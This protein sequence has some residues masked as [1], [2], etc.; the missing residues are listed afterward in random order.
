LAVTGAILA[1]LICLVFRAYITLKDP[2]VVKVKHQLSEALG[3]SVKRRSAYRGKKE[4]R[5]AAATIIQTWY[6]VSAAAYLYKRTR[7]V[8]G[9]QSTQKAEDSYIV[10]LAMVG[11]AT[12]FAEG[13]SIVEQEEIG[14]DVEDQ[15][16][17][18]EDQQDKAADSAEVVET[19]LLNDELASKLVNQFKIVWT[20][21]QCISSIEFVFPFELPPMMKVFCETFQGVVSIDILSIARQ[22]GLSHCAL[23]SSASSMSPC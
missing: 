10:T 19:I 7:Q 12:R 11:Q 13:D 3:V 5:Q 6:R 14:S 2:L 18:N 23:G 9:K 20:W 16:D 17:E 1:V 15:E 4:W 8:R 21:L 22:L